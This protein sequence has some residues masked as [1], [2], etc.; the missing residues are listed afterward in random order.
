MTRAA[1]K[2]LNVTHEST[3]IGILQD[4][5]MKKLLTFACAIAAA[6]TLTAPAAMT[7]DFS[8]GLDGF[9]NVALVSGPS[10]WAGAPTA[11]H[12]HSLGGWQVQMTKEFS[13]GPGGGNENQQLAM[14]ALAN[15]GNGR[16]RLDVMV[17]GASF[18][19]GAATWF[20]FWLVGN[21]DGAAG[22]TQLQVV[23]SYQNEGQ[24]DLRTWTIDRSFSQ[25]G[26]GPGDT[27][28]Q[29]HS[30]SN[31]DAA[32]PVN[33]Y[34]DNVVVYV[35]EPGSLGFAVLGGLAL[36]VSRRRR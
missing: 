23:D 34:L 27:W 20:Q 3:Y 19:T 17:D 11:Q 14:Q 13:W 16:F 6:G 22:W 9:Q 10:G 5:Y 4:Y 32:V 15:S 25:M 28:F 35:P 36:L 21:S 18:P 30:G 1:H 2:R 8:G 33:F 26:W 31:S 7:F 12:T 29:I 24:A